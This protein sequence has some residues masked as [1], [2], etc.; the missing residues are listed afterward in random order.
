MPGMV[1]RKKG[2]VINI[3]SAAGNVPT[4]LLTVYSAC[5]VGSTLYTA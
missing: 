5:K 1:A 4:P 2:V 3:A